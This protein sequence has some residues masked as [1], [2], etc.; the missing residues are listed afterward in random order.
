MKLKVHAQFKD[1]C[2]ISKNRAEKKFKIFNFL[3]RFFKL[4]FWYSIRFCFNIN[5]YFQHGFQQRG[6]TWNLPRIFWRFYKQ[7]SFSKTVLPVWWESTAASSCRN[8]K[9]RHQQQQQE[10]NRRKN[11]VAALTMRT[12]IKKKEI[13]LW[14]IVLNYSGTRLHHFLQN[15]SGGCFWFSLAKA[16]LFHCRHKLLLKLQRLF[17]NLRKIDCLFLSFYKR[18]DISFKG[19]LMQIWKSSYMLVFI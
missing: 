16:I 10:E 9:F 13:V 2:T 18:K 5:S 17:I 4:K 14:P 6:A 11:L 1:D 7:F 12:P 19:T 3:G 15:T 8:I